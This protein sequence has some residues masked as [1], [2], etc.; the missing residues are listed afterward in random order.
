MK[1]LIETLTIAA[2]IVIAEG[3]VF[4]AKLVV[5]YEVFYR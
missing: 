5:F 2:A 3:V 4:L 1:F